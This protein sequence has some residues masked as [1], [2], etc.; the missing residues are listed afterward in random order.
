M[1]PAISC[2]TGRDSVP[3]C[4]KGAISRCPELLSDRADRRLRLRTEGG[5][6]N[7]KTIGKSS[8]GRRSVLSPGSRLA[9]F[10]ATVGVLSGWFALHGQAS[11]A[12]NGPQ[13]FRNSKI[14]DVARK[15]VGKSRPAGGY[16]GA[17]QCIAWVRSWISEAGGHFAGGSGPLSDFRKSP[18]KE[19]SVSQ[20]TRGDV[21]QI[22]LG[23]TFNGR[24]HTGVLLGPRHSNGT[25]DVIEGNVPAGS[26]AGLSTI[27]LV[28]F[29]CPAAIVLPSGASERIRRN[30]NSNPNQRRQ[31]VPRVLPNSGSH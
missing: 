17:G 4:E 11:A 8:L 12:I 15:Y 10:I 13:N 5:T 26:G 9:V 24:P 29:G 20:A 2:Q 27:L 25:F 3:G 1:P 30:P 23:D 21:F 19:V 31:V 22:S 14:A 6:L 7:L 28:P 18:A 16:G